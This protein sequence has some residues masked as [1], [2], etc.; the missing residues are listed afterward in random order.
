MDTIGGGYEPGPIAR[1]VGFLWDSLVLG[2]TYPVGLLRA[3]RPFR[4]VRLAVVGRTEAEM[5]A[6]GADSLAYAAGD[7]EALARL[8]A[9]HPSPA[10]A[11]HLELLNRLA[12]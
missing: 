3:T 9:V 6:G 12:P 7:R 4:W 1:A 11:E 8:H 10:L 2:I 5:L